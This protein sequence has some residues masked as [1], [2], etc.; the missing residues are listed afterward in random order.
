M[1]AKAALI[2]LA[3]ITLTAFA[4]ISHP[5][6]FPTTIPGA[7]EW[8]HEPFNATAYL[9][10]AADPILSSSHSVQKHGF[11]GVYMCQNGGWRWPCW[12][13][14]ARWQCVDTG[15]DYSLGPDPG[16]WCTIHSNAG[17]NANDIMWRGLRKPGN[18]DIV[19]SGSW[20]CGKIL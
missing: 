6:P 20:S 12:W 18:A 5:S 10:S 3:F 11:P 1:F 4:H 2:L 14:P 7:D 15:S 8:N 17:C 19:G 16:V 13:Q 9:E